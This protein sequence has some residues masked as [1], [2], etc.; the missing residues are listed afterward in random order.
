M[1][2]SPRRAVLPL[3]CLSLS[4][5]ACGNPASNLPVAEAASMDTVPT[6]R[7][8][9]DAATAAAAK[10]A[11]VGDMHETA[12]SLAGWR[13][14]VCPA[15]GKEYDLT[16]R[17]TPALALAIRSDDW[18]KARQILLFGPIEPSGLTIE[19][20]ARLKTE[21]ASIRMIRAAA[22]GDVAELDRR[23]AEGGDPNINIAM[24]ETMTPLAWAAKC[25]NVAAVKY[26]ISKG[27]KVNDPVVYAIGRGEYRNSSALMWATRLGSEGAVAVLLKA[28][29]DPNMQVRF[30][31]LGVGDGLGETALLL[32]PTPSLTRRLLAAGAD[33]NQATSEGEVRLMAAARSNDI[34]EATLL[35][36]FGATVN[37]VNKDMKTPIDLARDS[38]H[39]E[40]VK[41]LLEKPESEK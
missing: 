29:A 18:V 36:K 3:V 28:G 17:D 12:E 34:E 37:L 13:R 9:G 1:R 6:L 8:T 33:P 2:V 41:L 26:L 5:A 22:V 27:A 4:L 15:M 7:A 40:M 11:P 39:G 23:V 32:S 20:A 16:A 38:G 24:D 14:E 19:Q 30:K 31:V 35:M 21:R 25:N 10:P